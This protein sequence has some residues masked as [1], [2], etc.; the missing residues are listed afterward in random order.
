MTSRILSTFAAVID[1]LIDQYAPFAP[2]PSMRANVSEDAEGDQPLV[3][4]FEVNQSYMDK[5]VNPTL[6]H[7]GAGKKHPRGG[8]KRKKVSLASRARRSAVSDSICSA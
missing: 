7:R 8:R 4:K 5:Y 3:H 1:N 6:F 2:K